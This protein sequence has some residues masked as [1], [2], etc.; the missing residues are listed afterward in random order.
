MPARTDHD[1]RDAQDAGRTTVLLHLKPFVRR[2]TEETYAVIE[3][4]VAEN[5]SVDPIDWTAVGEAAAYKVLSKYG[6]AL[7]QRKLDTVKATL[8][9]S[10]TPALESQNAIA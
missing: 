7:S 9:G 3:Q 4:E 2:M 10:E 6:I 1:R 5:D 8:V